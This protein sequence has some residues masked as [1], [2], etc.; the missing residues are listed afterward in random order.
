M[1]P[2]LDVRG[3]S[4]ELSTAAGPV[5]ALDGVELRVLPQQAVC[6]VGESGCGKTLT[7]LAVLGLLPAHARLSCS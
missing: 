1:E 3:L 2:V 7:A 4:V 5:R 6:L